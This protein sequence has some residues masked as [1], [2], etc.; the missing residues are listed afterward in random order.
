M[1]GKFIVF[2]GADDLGKTT[3]IELLYK[4]LLEK[5]EKVAK[6]REPGGTNIGSRIRDIL[7]N[8]KEKLPPKTQLFLFLADRNYHYEKVLKPKLE[9]GYIILCDRFYLSTLAYQHKLNGIPELEVET[10][11][12]YSTKG[13]EP[14]LSFIFAGERLTKNI[15]DEYERHIGDSHA[16][17]NKYYI[18]YS[19]DKKNHFLINANNSKDEV[20]NRILEIYYNN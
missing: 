1:K 4:Y 14:D 16:L 13:L 5:G 19:S 17:L 20:F 8:S 12:T 3:Q 9:Q 11:N 7:L 18:N 6:T 2:D 10:L 15:K